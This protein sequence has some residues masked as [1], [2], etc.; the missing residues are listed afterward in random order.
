MTPNMNGISQLHYLFSEVLPIQQ[1]PLDIFSQ[2][3]SFL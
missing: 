1:P 3:V 2:G